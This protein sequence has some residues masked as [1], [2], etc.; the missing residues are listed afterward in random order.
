NG[1]LGVGF[2]GGAG[3]GI[4]TDVVLVP[5]S[6]WMHFAYTNNGGGSGGTKTMYLTPVGQAGAAS[7]HTVSSNVD[8]TTGASD[9][10][11]QSDTGPSGIVAGRMYRFLIYN[12]ALS[13]SEVTQIYLF[14]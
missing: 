14:G 12:R 7:V 5:S 3:F 8:P 10:I 4:S 2:S 11:V 6:T 9:V 1:S 13:S